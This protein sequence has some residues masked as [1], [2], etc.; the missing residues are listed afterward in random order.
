[1]D[2]KF[3]A[4]SGLKVISLSNEGIVPVTE[5]LWIESIVLNGHSDNDEH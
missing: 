3:V 2:G 5:P 4:I 1:M